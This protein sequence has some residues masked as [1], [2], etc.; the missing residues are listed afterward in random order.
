[1]REAR[2]LNIERPCMK[3]LVHSRFHPNIGGI[4]TVAS[5]LA[6][7]WCRMGETVTVVS[8]VRCMTGQRQK[9]PFPV[10]YRPGLLQWLRLIRGTDVLVHMNLSLKALWPALIVRR[11]LVAVNHA[12]YYSDRSGYRDWRER[13][14]LRSMTLATNIAV[15]Q[16]VAQ[17]LPEPCVVIPNPVDVSLFQAHDAAPRNK[18]LVFLGRLVSDKGC[19]LLIQALGQL[20]E[21]GLRPS[22]TVI[23]NG[24]ERYPCEQL[25]RRLNLQEQVVFTGAPPSDQVAQLLRQ[26]HIMIV[27]SIWEESF[28]VVAL[29]GLAS[30]C[31]VLGSDGGGLAE[32]IGPCGMTFRRGDAAD[33]TSKLAHLLRHPEEWE[34]YRA[35]AQTHLEL[36]QPSW[37]ATRYLEVFELSL[38]K[39]PVVDGSIAL[40]EEH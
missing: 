16:A 35:G 6:H 17:R 12:Y 28:G 8:D 25:A 32:A 29:E 24:P 4:E 19:D 14:K 18:E 15:S 36:H 5:L 26:H 38:R 9:F 13:L 7:E 39:V 34:R 21:H 37:V 10:Y 3:I 2:T 23:G 30:G 20:A 1:M 11:P 22:L 27:P 33:L 40:S 31:V